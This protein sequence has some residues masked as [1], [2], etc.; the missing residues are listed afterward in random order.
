MKHFISFFIINTRVNAPLSMAYFTNNGYLLR[1][2]KYESCLVKLSE[3]STG[4]HHVIYDVA[5]GFR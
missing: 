2:K 5:S 1:I 3:V 4:S